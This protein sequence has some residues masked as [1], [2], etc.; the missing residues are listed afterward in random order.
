MNPYS[1]PYSDENDDLSNPFQNNYNENNNNNNND[2]FSNTYE[3]KDKNN[4]KNYSNSCEN[5]D[6]G[7]NNNK[8]FNLNE[9]DE[10]LNPFKNYLNND[11]NNN[12][13]KNIN[14]NNNDLSDPFGK[15]NKND[16]NKPDY[17]NPFNN[18]GND[19]E[20]SNPFEN[21]ENDNDNNQN[22]NNN[23]F[24]NPFEN[25]ENNKNNDNNE[26]SN[27][28][29]NNDY[30]K[31][32]DN[33]K[34][35][36]M[37]NDMKNDIPFNPYAVE[38]NNYNPFEENFKNNPFLNNYNQNNNNNN[39]SSQQNFNNNNNNENFIDNNNNYNFNNDNFNNQNNNAYYQQ[40]NNN[41]N[42]QNNIFN[43]QNFNNNINQNNQFGNQS[44]NKVIKKSVNINSSNE[45]D[46][47]KIKAIIEK[48]ESLYDTSK[49]QY[50]NFNI[51]EAIST[52]VKTIKGLDTLKNN[53]NK[54]KQF[55]SYLLPYVKGLR[56][57]SFS[58]LQEYR[59][60]VYKI[61][62]IRFRPAF[63]KPY[64]NPND[65]L[66]NFCSKYILNKPFIS[67]DDIYESISSDEIQ[68]LKYTLSSSIVQ[69]KK[70]GNKC[71]LIYGPKG[72]G[73]TLYVHALANYIGAKIA[74][75]DG[76]ELFKIPFFAREFVKA[77]FWGLQNNAII[78]YMRNIEQMFSTIN[79]FN[80]IYDKVSS[81]YHLNVYFFASSSINRYNLPKQV[82]DKFQFFQCVK[83][84]DNNHKSDYIRFIGTKIGIEIKVNEQNLNKF[85]MENLYNFTNEDIFDIIRNAIGI[86]KQ[87]SP[88]D[89]E[90]W[91][92]R[93]GL[94][95]DD[96]YKAL[97][98]VN[99]SLT[100][101]IR[102]SYY[103]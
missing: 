7:N 48:C 14:D 89:D 10:F 102:N 60:M 15:E 87:S 41:L 75:I 21:N 28:F 97:G 46:I 76:I 98:S 49:T 86:K 55:C 45:D 32:N 62:P 51:R 94:Y 79:N 8:N 34:I 81:S 29:E 24:L 56:D 64:E 58:T 16:N 27:P 1:N 101:E 92:Y 4:N 70:T 61:I 37:N 25:N 90:N 35:N 43:N 80:Y 30:N 67:F 65:S 82:V 20:F 93:E 99:G 96:L 39:F 78:I 5:K 44:N 36:N 31:N 33:N 74:Q 68:K 38:N 71:F 40:R 103:I 84:I 26:Y 95:E 57:K 85:V 100:Q 69:A 77:C 54:E 6:K 52:L 42:N 23:E 18:N 91:V 88:P 2:T 59:I 50:D 47:K 73:K 63:Y 11:N 9:N 12:N 19:N 3:D 66:I 72:C 83:P 22:N 13:V 53:I 17:N